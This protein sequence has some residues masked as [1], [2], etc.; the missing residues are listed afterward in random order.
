MRKVDAPSVSRTVAALCDQSSLGSSVDAAYQLASYTYELMAKRFDAMDSKL[1]TVT[2]FAVSVSLTIPVLARAGGISFHSGW[3]YGA[4][5]AFVVGLAAL[6]YP[7]VTSGLVFLT[8]KVLYED[9][10]SL[11]DVEFKR[12]AIYWAGQH[13]E[14]N[15]AMI[16]R[17]ARLL[18][19]GVSCFALEALL[20]AVWVYAESR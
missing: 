9:Y 12:T 16:D 20:V 8:P 14:R 7:R 19:T 13:F 1:N 18:A 4:G 3:L 5:I 11:T 17:N 2:T 6:T 15:A 10:L